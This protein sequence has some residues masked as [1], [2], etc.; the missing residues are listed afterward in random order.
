M[1]DQVD[2]AGPAGVYRGG[3]AAGVQLN[4]SPARTTA[5]VAV[6]NQTIDIAIRKRISVLNDR[7]MHIPKL[8]LLL[9]LN[10]VD[11]VG[12]H[13]LQVGPGLVVDRGW[14]ERNRIAGI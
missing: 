11:A 5:V 1:V 13:A 4:R 12:R 9:N 3:V 10:G 2:Q 6:N 7:A 8:V 14:I